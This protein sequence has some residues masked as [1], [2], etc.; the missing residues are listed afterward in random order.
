MECQSSLTLLLLPS[1]TFV[2]DVVVVP[3]V[4]PDELQEL[5]KRSFKQSLIPIL[6]ESRRRSWKFR[7][8]R[9]FIYAESITKA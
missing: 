4:L 6:F 3:T 2:V 5:S 7:L 8:I 9:L 1:F